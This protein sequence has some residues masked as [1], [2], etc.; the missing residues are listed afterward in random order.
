[1]ALVLA[2]CC[3]MQE[4]ETWA[5]AFHSWR[6]VEEEAHHCSLMALNTSRKDRHNHDICRD[7]WYF[8]E[9]RGHIHTT[10]IHP[11]QEPLSLAMEDLK[12]LL[13]EDLKILQ[14]LLW[15]LLRQESMQTELTWGSPG[16]SGTPRNTGIG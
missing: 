2:D 4:Q 16:S 13:M 3:T 12:V 11:L 10:S 7:V 14:Q 1:M 9:T 15:S 5:S 6:D 8:R